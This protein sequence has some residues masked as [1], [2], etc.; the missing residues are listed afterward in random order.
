MDKQ[1]LRFWLISLSFLLF[2]ITMNYLSP[3]VIIDGISQGI[4]VGSF[5]TFIAMFIGS[6]FLGRFWCGWMCPAGGIGEICAKK[7]DKRVI[8]K[9]RNIKYYIWGIWLSIII[10]LGILSGIITSGVYI[11]NPFYHTEFGISVTNFG[12][13]I[14]MTFIITG[15]VA[16]SFG[17]GKRGFCHTA[18]WMAPF[19]VLGVKIRNHYKKWPSYHLECNPKKCVNCKKCEKV[20]PMS[21]KVSSMVQSGM[22]ENIDCIQCGSCIS[23]CPKHAISTAW[24]WNQNKLPELKQRNLTIVLKN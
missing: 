11:I 1:K 22:M 4:L 19:M 14:L 8:G 3:Y 2:P 7:K 17:V 13:L 10:L 18:C 12:M 16:L 5:F 21:L 24:R 9:K 15:I 23:N 20:C 6:L